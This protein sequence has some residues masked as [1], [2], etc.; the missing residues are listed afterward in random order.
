MWKI[1]Y[2]VRDGEVR[3]AAI[4]GSKE[5]TRQSW[6]DEMLNDP[7]Y[8]YKLSVLRRFYPHWFKPQQLPL[9]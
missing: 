4:D 6:L 1:A 9:F 2:E 8:A 5:P 7:K 3:K